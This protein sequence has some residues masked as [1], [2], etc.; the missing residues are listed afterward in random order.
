VIW[1][2]GGSY[3]LSLHNLGNP[4]TA[5]AFGLP[6]AF[7][8]QFIPYLLPL[9]QQSDS[10]RHGSRYWPTTIAPSVYGG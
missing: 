3:G 4:K 8:A 7:L 1:C 5:T 2:C 6:K 9:E 10:E